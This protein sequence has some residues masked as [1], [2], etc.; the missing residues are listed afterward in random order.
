[1]PAG[2]PRKYNTPE[3]MQV[4]IDAYFASCDDDN[5]PLISG[6]AYHLDMTTESLR[7]YQSQD[8]F[9]AIVKK[10]KQRI[11]IAFEKNMYGGQCTG[12]IFWLKNNAG[13]RDKTE[14]E[15]TGANGGAIKTEWTVRMVDA[16]NDTTG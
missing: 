2:R 11:E 6:L 5:P 4:D 8:E 7:H 10:A 1:M 12:S 16:G 13:Y 15:L 14:Q 3:E 9:S